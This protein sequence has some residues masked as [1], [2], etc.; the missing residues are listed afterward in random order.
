MSLAQASSETQISS[1][2]W[3]GFAP[4]I[5]QSLVNVREFIQRNYTPYEG[6]GEFLQGSTERTRGITEA[7]TAARAGRAKGR[8]RCRRCL[9]ASSR[10]GGYIDKDREIIVGLQTDA[11]L[12]RAI[13]P[14]AAGAVVAG[15]SP[16][17]G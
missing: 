8:T 16:V 1:G 6:D 17:Y 15:E 9:R 14:L 13:M 2:P 12:K 3:R 10:T 5:W 7:A 11:P 4:G